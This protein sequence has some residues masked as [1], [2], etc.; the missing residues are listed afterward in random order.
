MKAKNLYLMECHVAGRQY[1]DADLV[2]NELKVG[3]PLKLVRDV[4]NRYDP[5]AIAVLF[6]HGGEDYVLG[7][8]PACENDFLFRMLEQGWGDCFVCHLSKID[9]DAHYEQQLR[10]TIRVRQNTAVADAL[11]KATL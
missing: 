2:W 6:E 10:M 9:D 4:E 7:Y 5:Q 8:V 1:H 3:A 11:P